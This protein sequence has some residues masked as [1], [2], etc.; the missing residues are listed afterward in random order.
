[1]CSGNPRFAVVGVVGA[2]NLEDYLAFGYSSYSVSLV[3][4]W[5][6]LVHFA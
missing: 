4:G 2:P 5:R 1:M 6:R 3:S